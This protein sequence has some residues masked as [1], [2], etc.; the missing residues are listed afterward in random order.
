MQLLLP[1]FVVCL[2]QAHCNR[3]RKFCGSVF[4]AICAGRRTGMGI[5][6]TIN[7][8][9]ENNRNDSD[10]IRR[11]ILT[12]FCLTLFFCLTLACVTSC[13][14]TLTWEEYA[15]E[16]RTLEEGI[17]RYAD[18]PIAEKEKL[19]QALIDMGHI[20]KSSATI[21]LFEASISEKSKHHLA[22]QIML[23]FLGG[24]SNSLVSKDGVY[25]ICWEAM[26]D[27]ILGNPST[28]TLKER[29]WFQQVTNMFGREDPDTLVLPND[30]DLPEKEAIARARAAIINA[31]GLAEDALDSFMP[32]ADLYITN[33]SLFDEA[34]RPNYRR[35]RVHFIFYQYGQENTG[36]L[37]QNYAA[38]VDQNGHVIADT[39]LG[40]PHV[41]EIALED[42]TRPDD[43]TPPIV[44]A[45][46]EYAESEGCYFPW[47]WSS[48]TKAEYS[49][50]IRPQVLSA[51]EKGDL[52]DLS[53][54]ASGGKPIQ[55]VIDS[56][57]FAYGLPE[58]EDMRESEAYHLAHKV[59]ED[60]YGLS[61]EDIE[62]YAVYSSFDVTDPGSPLWK[63][64]FCPESFED[65]ATVLL[66]KVE[67]NANTEELIAAHTIDWDRL[68]QEQMYDLLLY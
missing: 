11:F 63:F 24:D 38:I 46:R 17:G 52:A 20:R 60:K 2:P 22:D 9:I 43:G 64:L 42:K 56:A 58:K 8:R 34:P 13:A 27:A 32:D 14:A 12:I 55:E 62:Q 28:W 50:I 40:E 45:F 66:Y 6:M 68:F 61:K 59:L 57:V 30:G 25:A 33:S 48:E 10:K 31:Y 29:V 41:R 49:Q 47:K 65:M 3:K 16:V 26:T 5:Y 23:R 4:I 54:P 7:K 21:Q 36:T 1:C 15:K 53:T 44:Q 51:L 37:V 19:I 39:E 35:W 18:W 67:L